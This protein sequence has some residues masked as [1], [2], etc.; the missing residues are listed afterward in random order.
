MPRQI[1][2]RAI[3]SPAMKNLSNIPIP[4]PKPATFLLDPNTISSSPEWIYP[5][6][7][8]HPAFYLLASSHRPDRIQHLPCFQSACTHPQALAIAL[9]P[10]A[11]CPA[12]NRPLS[13][14]SPVQTPACPAAA[15]GQAGVATDPA[16]PSTWPV[17]APEFQPYTFITELIQLRT[18]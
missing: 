10:L 13:A 8:N 7:W 1:T 6:P 14:V 3:P 5:L 18:E 11:V 4:L 15:V 12:F 16:N 17:P 2:C 9:T